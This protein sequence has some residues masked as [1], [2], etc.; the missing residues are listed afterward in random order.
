MFFGIA[1]LAREE[2]VVYRPDALDALNRLLKEKY[3]AALRKHFSND[4]EAFEVLFTPPSG[5]TRASTGD[6]TP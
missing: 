4:H 3:V 5:G 2:I 6:A 1:L